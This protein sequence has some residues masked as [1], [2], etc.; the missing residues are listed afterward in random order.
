LFTGKGREDVVIR[1]INS[2]ADFYLQ[3]GGDPTVQFAELSH[4]IK[5]A[6]SRIRAEVS[7]QKS[8]EKYQDLIEHS[9]E[10]I[11]VAQ[12][13]MLKLVNQRTIE[14]P[15]LPKRNF[16]PCRFLSSSTRMTA[17]W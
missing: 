10:A 16:S 11:L 7:L 17:R 2:G 3:K 4:K 5:S 14:L 9:N 6:T 13:G 12:D 8:E 1:A 15:G